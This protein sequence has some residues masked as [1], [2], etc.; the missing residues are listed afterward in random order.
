MCKGYEESKRVH[1]DINVYQT[2][3]HHIRHSDANRFLVCFWLDPTR[4][5]GCMLTRRQAE[6]GVL[7]NKLINTVR[8]LSASA[9]F[10]IKDA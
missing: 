1:S 6:T 4:T 9:R 7:T 8:K 5:A 2:I 10:I 3:E